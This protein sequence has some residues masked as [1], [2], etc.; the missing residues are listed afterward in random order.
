MV[1]GE[2]LTLFPPGVEMLLRGKNI[3]IATGSAPVRPD[4]F[5]FGEG[6]IYDSDTILKLD[7]IPRTLAVVG[8]G[9]IGAEYGCTFRALG[10]EV[11]IVDGREGLPGFLDAEVSQALVRACERSG[12]IFHWKERV[13]KCI[14]QPTG[15]IRLELSSGLTLTAAAVLGIH[16]AKGTVTLVF[17]AKD[18]AH[19]QA[20]A[21]KAYVEGKE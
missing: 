8:A 21:L 17:G 10:A 18:I 5:P 4:L 14:P 16:A 11:H 15:D 13:Q 12:I 3:L 19:N 7:H 2:P 6:E 20:A 1:L 9:V